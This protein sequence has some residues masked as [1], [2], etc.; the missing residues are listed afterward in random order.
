MRAHHSDECCASRASP[1]R[2][3]VWLPDH[4]VTELS[5][6]AGFE[7]GNHLRVSFDCLRSPLGVLPMGMT[8]YISILAEHDIEREQGLRQSQQIE[9]VVVYKD[10][11]EIVSA[12]S[13]EEGGRDRGDSG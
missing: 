4:E 1:R 3:G 6:I 13:A 12:S 11:I 9:R 8:H 5:G 2:R 10:R 7:A